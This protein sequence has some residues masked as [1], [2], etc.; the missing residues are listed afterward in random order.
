MFASITYNSDCC[1]CSALQKQTGQ[2]RNVLVIWMVKNVHLNK[3]NYHEHGACAFICIIIVQQ[4]ETNYIM[5]MPASQLHYELNE[6][7]A[8]FDQLSCINSK[9]I[10]MTDI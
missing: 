4:S 10:T 1:C 6:T 8:R 7:R 9:K 5:D 3:H 2:L